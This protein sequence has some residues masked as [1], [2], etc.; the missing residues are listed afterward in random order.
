[1]LRTLEGVS[2]FRHVADGAIHSESVRRVRVCPNA[3][4]LGKYHQ[5]VGRVS[6]V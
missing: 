1:M 3:L 2:K 6:D 4:N 5:Q